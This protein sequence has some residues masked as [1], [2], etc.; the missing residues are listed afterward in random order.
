MTRNGAN[1]PCATASSI[2]SSPSLPGRSPGGQLRAASAVN[3]AIGGLI[4]RG[5][6]RQQADWVP[7]TRAAHAGTDPHTAAHHILDTLTTGDDDR[8]FDIH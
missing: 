2:S 3:H 7:E 6:T 4:G 8:R 5:Y 1:A